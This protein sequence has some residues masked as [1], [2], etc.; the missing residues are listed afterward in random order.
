M[1]TEEE[2]T[3]HGQSIQEAIQGRGQE[4][5]SAL[6]AQL[7]LSKYHDYSTPQGLISQVALIQVATPHMAVVTIQGDDP[8][9]TAEQSLL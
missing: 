5:G 6:P 4:A 8:V 7:T 3:E 2:Q 1:L 9:E